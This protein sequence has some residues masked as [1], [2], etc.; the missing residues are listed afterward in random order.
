MSFRG[1]T[2]RFLLLTAQI[3]R[4]A[5]TPKSVL[6]A[7]CVFTALASCFQLLGLGLIIP[8]VNG[9]VDEQHYEALLR[10]YRPWI[11]PL[12]VYLP[13]ELSNSSIFLSLV[14]LV[15]CCVY[16]ENFLLYLGQRSAAR[17]TTTT[18]HLLRSRAFERYL[19]L[20]KSFF[21]R[22][23]VGAVNVTLT[24]LINEVGQHFYHLSTF[25]VHSTFS[26]GFLLLMLTISWRL[27]LLAMVLIPITQLITM[28]LTKKLKYAAESEVE[29]MVTFSKKSLDILRNIELVL[30]SGRERDEI[31]QVKSISAKIAQ[32]GLSSRS[33]RF[34]LPR[35]IEGINSTGMVLLAC[36]ATFLFFK[37]EA[38][39]IGRLSVFFIALRRFGS[40]MEYFIS[41]W[42][43]CISNLPALERVIS[44]LE[45][46]EESKVV[47]GTN[48][49]TGIKDSMQ[50]KAVSFSYTSHA[51]KKTLDSITFSAAA[52][53]LTALVG[54]TGAGKTTLVSLIARFYE[55]QSGDILLDG[56]SI[57]DFDLQSLRSHIGFVSQSAHILQASVRENI[58]YGSPH[59]T[60]EEILEAAR[61]ARILDFIES[62]PEQFA[63]RLGEDGTP[64]SGGERQRI[65]I[66]RILLRNPTILILD[67]AT[68]ALDAETEHE[69][70]LAI[71][72]LLHDR[73]VFV[74]AHRLSTVRRADQVLVID[75]GRI[76]EQGSPQ[77][78]FQRGGK[79]HSYSLLQDTNMEAVRSS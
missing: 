18:S 33:R 35:L 55:Y 68:S 13:F 58:A 61:R 47:G 4:L 28:L 62:L 10:V 31:A 22:K 39:S 54:P 26:V 76:I 63:T 9:L 41:S 74:I 30:L 70:Q 75:G 66:A 38:S 69:V 77:E 24:N 64:I 20:G 65:S 48:H 1:S 36:G 71:E 34:L 29:S 16:F 49:F 51:A 46:G 27:T 44:L 15:L 56:R 32:H 79:F 3:L 42:A 72:E 25:I 2:L 37:V 52:S 50:F 60:D 21:D 43:Q 40:Q 12:Q 19:T 6:L 23:N 7:T 17:L 73:M 78:L 53:S 11:Q 5:Q 67:E 59:A 45:E 14:L 8:V 57:R